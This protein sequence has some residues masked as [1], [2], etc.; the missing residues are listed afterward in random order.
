MDIRE[1][2][3]EAKKKKEYHGHY[4]RC[5]ERIENI[6]K[7]AHK[8][9]LIFDYIRYRGRITKTKREY[10]FTNESRK[11]SKNTSFVH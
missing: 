11:A 10:A 5:H 2:V 8:I 3:R 9:V 7:H 1:K 6:L 4:Q